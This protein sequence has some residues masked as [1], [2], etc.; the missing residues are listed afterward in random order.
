MGPLVNGSTRLLGVIGDPIAQVR[1][2]GV[3]TA[4]FSR[5]GV[6]AVCV[7]LHVPSSTL[8]AF[9]D[10]VRTLRNL[11]GLIVTIPHK[12]AVLQLVDEA[13]DRARQVGAVNVVR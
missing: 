6:N 11:Q 5:N 12:P 1:A 10:I 8:P 7:P 4:L 9:F 2:P 3:W 13:T